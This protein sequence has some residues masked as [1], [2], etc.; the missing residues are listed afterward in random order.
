MTAFS[1]IATVVAWVLLSASPAAAEQVHC[2]DPVR[3]A[4]SYVGRQACDHQIVKPERAAAIREERREYIRRSMGQSGPLT[5]PAKYRSFGSGFFVHPAGY[6]VTNHHVVARCPKLSVLAASGTEHPAKLVASSNRTDLALLKASATPPA[7]AP[8]VRHDLAKG[9]RLTI[10]GFPVQKLPRRTPLSMAGQYLGERAAPGG[11]LV[12]EIDA[13]VWQGSSGS[14]A[15]DRFGRVTGVVFAKANIP[16][17]YQR[18]GVVAD[19]RTYAVPARTLA[20]FLQQQGVN[21]FTIDPRSTPVDS[22][23]ALVRINC[24]N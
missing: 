19:D 18:S 17:I 6:V 10:S 2:Y 9:A 1:T 4:L 22:N 8:V 7:V 3:N 12:M 23:G 16:G 14:P 11:R 20:A 15:F 21:P 24:L 5:L 13:L